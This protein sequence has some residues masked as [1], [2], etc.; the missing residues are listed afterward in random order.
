[1]LLSPV[2]TPVTRAIAVFDLLDI[3][4]LEGHWS[5]GDNFCHY[6]ESLTRPRIKPIG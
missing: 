2:T 1:M 5:Y 6:F 3:L 4:V